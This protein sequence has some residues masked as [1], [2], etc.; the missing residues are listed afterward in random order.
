MPE[1]VT[2]PSARVALFVGE[3][4]VGLVG[5][6]AGGSCVTTIVLDSPPALMVIVAALEV[7]P[8][9]AVVVSVNALPVLAVD[10]VIQ[11]GDPLKVHD[12]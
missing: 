2:S 6:V 10:G 4:I 5:A 7:V 11:A 8:V 1:T 12:D 3:L 9:L